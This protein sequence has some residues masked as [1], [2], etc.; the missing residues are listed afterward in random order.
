[1]DNI[2]RHYLVQLNVAQGKGCSWRYSRLSW[3]LF[4]ASVKTRSCIL[5]QRHAVCDNLQLGHLLESPGKGWYGRRCCEICS[6]TWSKWKRGYLQA[7]TFHKVQHHPLANSFWLSKYA[8]LREQAEKVLQVAFDERT[9]YQEEKEEEKTKPSTAVSGRF[10]SAGKLFLMLQTKDKKLEPNDEVDSH[11][12]SRNKNVMPMNIEGSFSFFLSRW[13][14]RLQWQRSWWGWRWG[15]AWWDTC[16]DWP[17]A[18]IRGG[19][20]EYEWG[21]G[22]QERRAGRW[23]RCWDERQNKL[24]FRLYGTPYPSKATFRRS[25]LT[26]PSTNIATKATCFSQSMRGAFENEYSLSVWYTLEWI[27]QIIN[28]CSFEIWKPILLLLVVQGISSYS[29]SGKPA[30]SWREL[31]KLKL[32]RNRLTRPLSTLIISSTPQTTSHRSLKERPS[33]T[34]RSDHQIDLRNHQSGAFPHLATFCHTTTSSPSATSSLERLETL[35]LACIIT[36]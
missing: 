15:W 17:S 33:S 20:Q 11:A 7:L 8:E 9:L 25:H 36:R 21:R 27:M 28:T 10:R 31:P 19:R 3:H 4:R 35:E 12:S 6:G 14:L 29:I 5:R 30:E 2:Q 22:K 23:E 34:A 18:H 13:I 24:E 32:S 16:R 1:M 26:H